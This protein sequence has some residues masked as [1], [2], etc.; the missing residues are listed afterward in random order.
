MPDYL[1]SQIPEEVWLTTWAELEEIVISRGSSRN[2][3]PSARPDGARASHW[4]DSGDSI[5]FLK[6]VVRLAYIRMGYSWDGPTTR[7]VANFLAKLD[8]PVVKNKDWSEGV[9]RNKS[10]PT[11]STF[12]QKT[13]DYENVW[14]L[15][16]PDQ[17]YFRAALVSSYGEKCL[18]S[19]CE[20]KEALEA[21]HIQPHKAGGPATSS[22]GLLLRRDLHRLFDI[23]LIAL[24]PQTRMWRFHREIS[25][26]YSQLIDG[27]DRPMF[28]K[29]DPRITVLSSHW[30]ASQVSREQ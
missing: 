18:I 21:C 20:I 2:I 3:V 24:D 30:S 11:K 28:D 16:R 5:V 25:G 29:D 26:H 13:P 27:Q 6:A 14:R 9:L 8:F 1:F 7:D 23:G 12:P 4:L 19:G 22:N 10:N 15:S 17:A